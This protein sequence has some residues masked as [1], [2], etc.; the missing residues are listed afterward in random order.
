MFA[1]RRYLP[2]LLPRFSLSSS[3]GPKGFKRGENILHTREMNK[4]HGAG[5]GSFPSDDELEE[6]D[7]NLNPVG[8]ANYPIEEGEELRTKSHIRYKVSVPRD[9]VQVRFSRSSGPGGQN[10]NKVEVCF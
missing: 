3:R 10:V 9:K 7:R 1:L 8:I 4:I 6:L 2:A 5:D